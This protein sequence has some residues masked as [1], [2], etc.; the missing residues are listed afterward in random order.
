MQKNCQIRNR[1]RFKFRKSNT[2]DRRD[3][4]LLLGTYCDFYSPTTARQKSKVNSPGKGR[5]YE[6]RKTKNE[7]RY[8]FSPFLIFY[9]WNLWEKLNATVF[10]LSGL[11]EKY[12]KRYESNYFAFLVECGMRKTVR[13]TVIPVEVRKTN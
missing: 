6:T 3:N 10:W 5:T 13:D 9:N 12:G 2:H 11:R 4:A 8:P 1:F 7:I